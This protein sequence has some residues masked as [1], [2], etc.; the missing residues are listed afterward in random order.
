[1]CYAPARIWL[2][3]IDFQ[4][5]E[6]Q[7]LSGSD[8]KRRNRLQYIHKDPIGLINRTKRQ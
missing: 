3:L 1:M 2:A 7:S 6:Q 4:N 5:G 8:K